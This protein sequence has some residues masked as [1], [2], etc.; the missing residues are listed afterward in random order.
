[1]RKDGTQFW[2]CSTITV[3]RD[4]KGQHRGYV[5]VIQDLTQRRHAENL[6]ETSQR[7]HEFIAMLAHELRNPLAPIR[8]AVDLMA[9]KGMGDST[10][11]A[12]RATIDRQSAA[13]ARIVDELL[14]VDRI[15]RG[16]FLI[17]KGVVDLRDVMIRAVEA[18][19]PVM[20]ANGHDFDVEIPQ[21][22]LLIHG[23]AL[24]LA[25]ALINLL[26][27]AARYTPG[28]GHV[29]LDSERGAT[30]VVLRVRDSG[31]GID[32]AD[33]ERIF[34]LFTQVSPANTAHRGGLGVGL[35]LVRRVAEL[36][37]GTVR[38]TSAGID[39]GSE[40]VIRLPLPLNR[41]EL[42]AENKHSVPDNPPRL[43]V[44]VADDNEDAADSLNML[45]QAIGQDVYAVYDGRAAVQAVERLQPDVLILDIGMPGMSG[46]EVA[47][48]LKT[49]LGETMPVLVAVTGWGQQADRDEAYQRG[50]QY[51]FTKPVDMAAL[52]EVL[53]TISGK[54]LPAK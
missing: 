16:Q 30:D 12:M 22:P 48:Q 54:G 53:S 6:A 9:R 14:D 49:S 3:S 44:V 37:G 34:D 28:G 15:A 39:K 13:L 50:F 25:Q 32:P 52:R 4:S 27:N 26:I 43:K 18:S 17:E 21:T 20:D 38:A 19:Q 36:H 2:A 1:V 31:Q 33:L 51:H 35:A 40:F 42:V 47:D 8:N 10:L 5:Q 29:R 7:M 46:Y 11:E 24:R 23:D 41:L 45:L